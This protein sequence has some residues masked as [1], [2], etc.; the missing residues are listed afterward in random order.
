MTL[1]YVIDQS[2]ISISDM[3]KIAGS[4]AN[5]NPQDSTVHKHLYKLL[6]LISSIRSYIL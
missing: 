6:C 5:Q 3:K 1:H 4:E 2:M